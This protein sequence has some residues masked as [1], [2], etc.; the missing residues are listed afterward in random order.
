MDEFYCTKLIYW[1]H[2]KSGEILPSSEKDSKK[3]VET[4]S[5]K[6]FN[7]IRQRITKNVLLKCYNFFLVPL[8]TELW[9]ETQAKVSALTDDE[10]EELFEVHATKQK[11]KQE[12]YLLKQEL[13]TLKEQEANFLEAAGNFSKPQ[14]N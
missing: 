1:E 4:L 7:E 2:A 3:F 9:G 5:R 6:L 14:N 11:Y 12:E 13:G 8:Q 10:I